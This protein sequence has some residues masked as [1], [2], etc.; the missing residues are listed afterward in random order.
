MR[1]TRAGWACEILHKLRAVD[2]VEQI[3]VGGRT[4]AAARSSP[5]QPDPPSYLGRGPA[6]RCSRPGDS[7][8][9]PASGGTILPSGWNSGSARAYRERGFGRRTF[10]LAGDDS[11]M[12]FRGLEVRP[13][14][15]LLA[16]RARDFLAGGP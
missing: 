4:E 16:E 3:Q 5:P 2:E 8:A 9:G 14:D 11:V 6:A 12:A 1:F 10:A 13:A 15:T 7:I